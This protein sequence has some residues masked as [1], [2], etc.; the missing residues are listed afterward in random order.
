MTTDPPTAESP[1]PMQ[2]VTNKE[3]EATDPAQVEQINHG[4]SAT[5]TR[6]GRQVKPPA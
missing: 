5:A 1:T 3:A 6:S 2:G 4:R